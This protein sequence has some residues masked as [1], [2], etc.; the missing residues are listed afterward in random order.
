[1]ETQNLLLRKIKEQLEAVRGQFNAAEFDL[2]AIVSGFID[3][4]GANLKGYVIENVRR[5][6]RKSPDAAEALSGERL[7]ALRGELTDALAPEA[8]RIV[9]ELRESGAWHEDDTAF[10][11]LNS[12]IWKSVKSVEGLANEILKKYGLK[13]VNM[14][15]W[16]WLSPEIDALITTRFP[17]AKKEFTDKRK[18]L[19]YLETR[20]KEESRLENVLNKLESL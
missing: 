12:K 16:A 4:I 9:R 11:D 14:K 20:Y 19:N 1:M 7:E 18:Q 6:I 13:P 5:E 8:G 15:N 2:D 10:I 3:N 17:A